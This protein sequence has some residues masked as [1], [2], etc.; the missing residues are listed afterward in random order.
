MRRIGDWGKGIG[1]R[2]LLGARGHGDKGGENRLQITEYRVQ[3]T[4]SKSA[5]RPLACANVQTEKG[6]RGRVSTQSRPYLISN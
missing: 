6:G 3:I 4:E 1:D 5:K 2:G